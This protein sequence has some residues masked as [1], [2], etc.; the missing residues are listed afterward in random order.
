MAIKALM[1]DVDGVLVDGRPEDGRHWQT[2]LEYDLAISASGL[3]Q[4]LF[5]PY[6]EDIILGRIEL[7]DPLR[8]VLHRI[9]PNA[10]PERFVK[11]WFEHDSRVVL[12]L[13]HGLSSLRSESTRV[14]LA[15]NQEHMRAAYLMQQ[16]GLSKHIDGM[17]YSAQLGVKK[18]EPAFF[19]SVSSRVGLRADEL[20]LI[21][22]SRSNVDAARNAGWRVVHRTKEH[23]PNDLHSILNR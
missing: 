6:W 15:T 2:S 21:D 16:M 4:E 5:A 8:P 11:H 19:T 13:L 17:F 14:Y 7:M 20:L 23:S 9:A 3:H 22:D 12:P 18:P 1:I 10:I